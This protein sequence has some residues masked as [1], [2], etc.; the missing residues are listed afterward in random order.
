[1]LNTP[2]WFSGQ[3]NPRGMTA[4]HVEGEEMAAAPEAPK[5]KATLG[6]VVWGIYGAV[7]FVRNS[8]RE[9]RAIVLITKPA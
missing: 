2:G 3:W 9:G 1:L 5:M 4:A 7:Y 8:R 6:S